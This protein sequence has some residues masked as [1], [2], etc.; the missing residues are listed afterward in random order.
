MH[1]QL[2]SLRKY[3]WYSFLLAAES[4]LLR[5]E[6]L[7]QCKLPS[8]IELATFLFVVQGLKQLGF[9]IFVTSTFRFHLY[10]VGYNLRNCMI[11]YAV[12]G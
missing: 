6:V 9:F 4:N 2:L 1:W 3:S 11:P 10:R 12:F 5:P 7:S 8:G